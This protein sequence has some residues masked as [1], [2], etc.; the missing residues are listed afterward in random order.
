LASTR[1]IYPHVGRKEHPVDAAFWEKSYAKNEIFWDH[2]EPSPGLVD[3]LAKEKYTRGSVL[4]PGCGR[5]HDCLEFARHGFSVTGMDI[6]RSGIKEARRL[7][8]TKSEGVSYVIGD[9]LKLPKKMLG[10]FDW[11]FEHTCFCA[12]DPELRPQYVDFV[13]TAL[14]PNGRSLGVFYNIQPESG[15]P[16][17]TTREEL[18]ERFSPQFR[19]LLEKVPRSF[20]NREGKELLMLWERKP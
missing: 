8:Q 18:I 14:K 1:K 9:C 15:P 17:G 3:F 2:G 5:G 13:V 16:F 7:A 6:S 19:L 4:V 12:I 10:T 11:V 20:P